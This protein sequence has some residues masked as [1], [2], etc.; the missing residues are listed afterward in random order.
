MN[1]KKRGIGVVLFLLCI[2]VFS[3][4]TYAIMLEKP[5]SILVAVTGFTDKEKSNCTLLMN[6]YGGGTKTGLDQYIKDQIDA[7]DPDFYVKSVNFGA[8]VKDVL[9]N[10]WNPNW[11]PESLR[12]GAMATKLYPWFTINFYGDPKKWPITDAHVVDFTCDQ[13]YEENSS[14]ENT[15]NSIDYTWN[16]YSLRNNQLLETLYILGTEGDGSKNGLDPGNEMSQYG[17]KYWADNGKVWEWMFDYYYDNIILTQNI[18]VDDFVSANTNKGQTWNF[19]LNI[20]NNHVGFD[21]Y[22]SL[23]P[24]LELTILDPN[25][26]VN[27]SDS[28]SILFKNLTVV[29][30]KA[31]VW[32][33]QIYN[34]DATDKHTAFF[35]DTEVTTRTGDLGGINFTQANLN[36][37]STCNPSN[38]LEVVLKGTE[39]NVSADDT[40]IN[41]TNATIEATDA[42]LTAL[43]IPNHKMW[44]TM[45]TKPGPGFAGRVGDV[46]RVDDDLAHT[47]LGQILFDA[48]IQ[49]KWDTFGQS[50]SLLNTLVNDW[51]DTV[52]NDPLSVP[53]WYARVW[54]SPNSVQANGTECKIFLTNSSLKVQ[55]EVEAVWGGGGTEEQ[56][57]N[58]KNNLS[59]GLADIAADAEIKVNNISDSAYSKIRRAY[60]SVALAQWYKEQNRQDLVFNEL[61]DS[62][63]LTGLNISFDQSYYESQAWQHLYTSWHHGNYW[64]SVYGGVELTAIQ[65]DIEGNINN[66]TEELM[67][68]STIYSYT[69]EDET[70]FFAT[71]KKPQK[72][73]LNTLVVGFNTL[74]PEANTTINTTVVVWNKGKEAA[75]NFTIYFYD[76]YTY[77]NGYT[78]NYGIGT[79]DVASLAADTIQ[80]HSIQWNTSKLGRH[81]VYA[82]VDYNNNVEETNE[83]NN[84]KSGTIDV[85]TPYPTAT[86]TSPSTD[87]QTLVY[88]T[89]TLTGYGTDL[90]DGYLT[91][92]NWSSN[93]DG[94]LGN[95][96]SIT[97]GLSVG[98]HIITLTVTDSDGNTATD[99][100]AVG[101]TVSLPPTVSISSPVNGETIPEGATVY[102]DGESNDPEDGALTGSS[103]NWTS[104]IDGF[105][106][107]GTSFNTNLLSV[108]IHSITFTAID[109]TDAVG[110]RSITIT[111]EEG[112]PTLSVST[113]NNNQE[114]YYTANISF[115][116]T[117][118]DPQ[119]GNI[120]SLVNWVSNIDGGIGNGNS[121]S[122]TL[123]VGKHTIT[124]SIV[125]SHGL[126]ATDSISITV[127]PP[128]YPSVSIIKPRNLQAFTHPE[129][130]TFKG[131]ANDPEDGT[132]SGASLSW[133]SNINGSIGTG[134]EF[135][136]NSSNLGVGTHTIT[137]TA[138]DSDSMAAVVGVDVTIHSSPPM[139][140]VI[141]PLDKDVFA[142]GD[143]ITFNGTAT[144]FEDGTLSGISLNWTSSK[145]GFLGNGIFGLTN[146]S[147]G[148]HLITLTAE[149]SDKVTDSEGV[150]I[151]IVGEN[152]IQI[153][154]LSDGSTDKNLT[155]TQAENQ[156]VY[157]KLPIDAIITYASLWLRGFI[158]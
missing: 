78:A 136:Y 55:S 135:N 70:Y 22:L 30:P 126:T 28:S 16:F 75:N 97:T 127:L 118:S 71:T 35:L 105:L 122:K 113:P 61:I 83:L 33:I 48:D 129:N 143:N 112:T 7:G 107:Y 104:S 45:D 139:A 40:I 109:S 59:N 64:Y 131:Q 4:L 9:P 121:F 36:Y 151:S 80:L 147:I 98:N 145:D 114:F 42:F 89:T 94:Y 54:I 39:A 134:T 155:Y 46:S 38:G 74:T 79:K 15:N 26:N 84:D 10:E 68:N 43:V 19:Y 120:S 99:T 62:N 154:Q 85:L 87:I 146:L 23:A 92:L 81:A 125:D 117:A 90:Q 88:N 95:E 17:T 91:D 14:T 108:G 156:T 60:A 72:P 137:L 77:P 56:L 130:I 141:S 128:Q 152:S 106:S 115:S 47:K 29:N 123:S 2:I 8:Y 12:A 66:A 124:T 103:L 144:D 51:V 111:I 116:G 41:I 5:D 150:T 44:I 157:V 110:S 102:F 25:D 37:I 119:D 132:L 13:M 149:D 133:S 142:Q 52:S 158:S 86:I 3:G 82:V 93:I 49:L 24:Y 65:T 31:G 27:I 57:Q 1:L 148:T 63:D 50:Q 18:E 32:T 96:T 58:F 138:T 34:N 6:E 100:V 101:V 67:T 69:Q 21:V 73:D 20:P 76:Q 153:N 140:A 11:K 53:G